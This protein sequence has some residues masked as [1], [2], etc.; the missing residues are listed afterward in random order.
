[1]LSFS[2]IVAELLQVL[3]V[4]VIIEIVSGIRLAKLVLSRSTELILLKT[5]TSGRVETFEQNTS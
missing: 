2:L 3:R 5:P 1:M 4:Q